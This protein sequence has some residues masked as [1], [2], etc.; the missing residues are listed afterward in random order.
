METEQESDSENNDKDMVDPISM[1][2]VAESEEHISDK[3]EQEDKAKEGVGKKEEDEIH[4]MD[5]QAMA[6]QRWL[7]LNKGKKKDE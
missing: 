6:Y 7:T 2:E 5:Y 4:P 1:Q 3:K